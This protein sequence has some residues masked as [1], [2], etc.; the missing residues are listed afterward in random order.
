MPPSS[1]STGPRAASTGLVALKRD[2]RHVHQF[3]W[4]R[5]S[6]GVC[7]AV[8]LL[9]HSLCARWAGGADEDVSHQLPLSPSFLGLAGA[10]EGGGCE[11]EEDGLTDSDTMFSGL[12][13]TL[14]GGGSDGLISEREG[15][16]GDVF[17]MRRKATRDCED[18]EHPQEGADSVTRRMYTR[19]KGGTDGQTCNEGDNTH[20][21]VAIH[22]FSCRVCLTVIFTR[23]WRMARGRV[24]ARTSGGDR[25]HI[26]CLFRRQGERQR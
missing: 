19:R 24:V 7:E 12:C 18:E 8:A 23:H 6:T 21:D 1:S 11:E 4:P 3:P 26:I 9:T 14:A 2:L 5:S 16:K 17:D 15:R 10:A 22:T 25:R 20:L 13:V